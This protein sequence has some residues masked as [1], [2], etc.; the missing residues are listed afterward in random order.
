[1]S[2]PDLSIIC[3]GIRNY[4]WKTLYD[5]VVI[6]Y[7]VEFIFVGPY[8]LP[9]ELEHTNIKYCR[10]FGHAN[11]CQQ[12]GLNLAE[13]LATTWMAD[14]GVFHSATLSKCM[15]M[16]LEQPDKTVITT[17]Y[18]EGND[19]VQPDSYYKLNN[20][21]PHSQYIPNDWWIL[22]SGVFH[23]KYIKAIGGWDS[24]FEVPCVAHADLAVRVQRN[25][26]NIIMLNESICHCTH[27]PDRTGDHGPI[28]D[29]QIEHD[30]PLYRGMYSNQSC[31]SRTTIDINNW[32]NASTIWERRFNV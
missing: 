3:A 20:A 30:T 12:I 24:Q 7:S 8:A 31:L 25:G 16:L 14:D 17:K 15:A 11:R 10:D 23:T 2:K 21:Y 1:M 27:M 18:T 6:P 19:I 32:Q 29:A 28:H 9:K 4:N 5:S 22:N 26:A 13:G